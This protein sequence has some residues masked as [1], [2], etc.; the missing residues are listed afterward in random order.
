[1]FDL[2]NHSPDGFEWG[3]YGSGPAQLALALAAHATGSDSRATAVYQRLKDR[4]VA[5]LGPA[6]SITQED[7][8]RMLAELEPPRRQLSIEDVEADLD[9][10]LWTSPNADPKS[11]VSYAPDGEADADDVRE[12]A[13]RYG[14]EVGAAKNG[15]YELNHHF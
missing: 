2:R 12:V 7:L 15:S 4:F 1:R 5:S 3:Y 6:W 14:Y 9:G 8:L 10:L 11:K 13:K